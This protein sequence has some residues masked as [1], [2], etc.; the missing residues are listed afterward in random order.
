[1]IVAVGAEV[2]VEVGLGTVTEAEA[3][4]E[5]EVEVE[6]VAELV[7]QMTVTV[8]TR[9]MAKMGLAEMTTAQ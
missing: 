8:M 1:L 3:E 9:A 4:I 2:E 7:E 6:V 5:A